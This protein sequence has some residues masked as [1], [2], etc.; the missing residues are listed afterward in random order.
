M[1]PF[2]DEELMAAADGELPP[3][4]QSELDMA[5]PHDPLLIRRL[6]RFAATGR[7]LAK[8]FNY[9]AEEIPPARLVATIMDTGV[10]AP[11]RERIRPFMY[12][13]ALLRRLA[14]RYHVPVWSVAAVP[15]L[16]TVLALL[17]G[18][19]T[20]PEGSLITIGKQGLIAEAPLRDVLETGASGERHNLA[21]HRAVT[22][23]PTGTYSS[24]REW[25]RSYQLHYDGG[26][27]PGFACRAGDQVWRI[28]QQ[29]P[30]DKVS[31]PAEDLGKQLGRDVGRR[32]SPA[33]EAK[34]IGGRWT[35]GH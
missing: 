1:M 33:E 26:I 23:W 19:S 31:R 17:V 32:L 8:P 12:S 2:S 22:A 18:L 35:Q 28:D 34:V 25:C 7:K 20:L 24:N 16:A 27:S 21:G 29:K 14:D 9:L 15:A 3:A 5:L 13:R 11:P 30:I 4:R 10:A 6:E